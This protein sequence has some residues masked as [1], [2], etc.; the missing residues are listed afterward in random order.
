MAAA[1][2]KSSD[3]QPADDRT[4][5]AAVLA[6]GPTEGPLRGLRRAADGGASAGA[7]GVEECN[8]LAEN[9]AHRG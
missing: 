5:A 1:M 4:I 9:G 2:A 8:V 6:T 7:V 3:A